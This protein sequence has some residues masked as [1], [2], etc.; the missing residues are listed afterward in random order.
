MVPILG[1]REG[2]PAP[3][4][5]GLSGQQIGRS[6]SASLILPIIAVT[7]QAK[8]GKIARDRAVTT[9]VRGVVRPVRLAYDAALQGFLSLRLAV[10]MEDSRPDGRFSDDKR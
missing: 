5:P 8:E 3:G 4:G 9:K 7:H 6:A 2:G 10:T 1:N